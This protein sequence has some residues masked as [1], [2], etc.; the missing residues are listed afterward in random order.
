MELNKKELPHTKTASIACQKTV[1]NGC[2][3][4]KRLM[5]DDAQRK[6]EKAHS[7]ICVEEEYTYIY[8]KMDTRTSVKMKDTRDSEEEGY[9]CFSE[10][11]GYS[12]AKQCL[13][14]QRCPQESFS[15]WRNGDANIAGTCW[16]KG[17]ID[18]KMIQ[19]KMRAMMRC[20]TGEYI[21]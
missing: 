13:Y 3:P 7:C 12:V 9:T 21:T 14:L 4:K 1:E 11:K 17:A 10:Q 8:E 5:H 2:L 15:L 18:K 16:G 6:T 19:A 20:H